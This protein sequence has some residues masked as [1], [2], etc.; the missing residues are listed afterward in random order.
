MARIPDSTFPAEPKTIGVG[1]LQKN[2]LKALIEVISG[3]LTK[4]MAE[5]KNK[6]RV[7]LPLFLF[8]FKYNSHQKAKEY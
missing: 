7:S 4:F 1:D 2:S 8:W 3:I 5:C 6:G